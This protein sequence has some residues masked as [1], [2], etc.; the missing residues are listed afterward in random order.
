VIGVAGVIVVGL[1]VGIPIS[2]I[3]YIISF[4]ILGT[5]MMG[6]LGVIG[7]IWSEKFDHIAAYS[8]FVITPL[9]FLSGTFYSIHTL[10]A[11][12]EKFALYN[13]V[14]YMIDGF[15]AGFITQA[16]ADP[17]TGLAVL[18]GTNIVLCLIIYRLSSHF[19]LR[20]LACVGVLCALVLRWMIS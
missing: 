19:S 11:A 13:P 8:N 12:W 5:M 9:T 4:S 6:A 17:M 10:P 2:N 14:F 1:I 16:D 18:V 15:R 7:G 3:W 20:C